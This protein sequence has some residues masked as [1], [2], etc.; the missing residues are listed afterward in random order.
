MSFK[1]VDTHIA[2]ENIK[3]GDAVVI[4][5]KQFCRRAKSG[6]VNIA[7]IADRD[8]KKGKKIAIINPIGMTFSADVE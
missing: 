8:A 5:W 6:N 1:L 2:R 3:E 4:L 7:G